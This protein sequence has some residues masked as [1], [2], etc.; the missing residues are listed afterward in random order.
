MYCLNGQIK[1]NMLL[2]TITVL[3]KWLGCLF[4]ALPK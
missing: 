2:I 1:D 4:G 3:H